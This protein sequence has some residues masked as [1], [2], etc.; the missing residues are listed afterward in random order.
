VLV[1]ALPPSLRPI[2]TSPAGL[3]TVIAIGHHLMLWKV[4]TSA[5]ALGIGIELA[6][7]AALTARMPSALTLAALALFALALFA[8]AAAMW[9]VNL[10]F[11]LTVTVRV[12]AAAGRGSQPP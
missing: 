3:G 5:F 9:V 11:R 7:L 4:A 6:G 8:L 2:Y 1:A 12:A 10:V